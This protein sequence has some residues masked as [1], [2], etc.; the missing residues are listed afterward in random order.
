[1]QFLYVKVVAWFRPANI[2]RI[3]THHDPMHSSANMYHTSREKSNTAFTTYMQE[4]RYVKAERVY[5]LE[6]F[7]ML[8]GQ[9]QANYD[10]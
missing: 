6:K 9:Y 3:Q 8:L 10:Q 1:M 7:H 5:V 2:L 4:E